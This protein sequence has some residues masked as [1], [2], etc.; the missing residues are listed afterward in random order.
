M[1]DS[2][3][4]GAQDD[5]GR[6]DARAPDEDVGA[7]LVMPSDSGSEPVDPEILKTCAAYDQ[8]DTDNGKRLLAH[9]GA[10]LRVFNEEGA[11]EPQ[12]VAWRGR[13]WDIGA[14]NL[15]AH[16]VAQKV[17]GRI[18]LEAEFIAGTPFEQKAAV[19]GETASKDLAAL[20]KRKDGWSDKDTAK[21]KILKLTAEAGEAA[22]EAVKKRRVARRKFAVSSKNSARLIAMLKCAAPHCAAG[23]DDFNPDPYLFATNGHTLKFQRAADDEC[24][25]PSITRWKARI[26]VFDGHRREDM[27]TRFV[28]HDYVPGATCPLWR[29]FLEEFLPEAD[30][31]DFVQTFSGLGLIGRTVQKLVFHYG[32]GAN[33]KSVFLETLMR[34]LGPLA[35]GLP[36]ESI[37]GQGE[38]SAGGASP[39]LARL[40]AARALRV[41]ELPADKPLHEDLVKKLTGGEKIPV[42]TLFKGYFEFTPVFSCHMSGNG[43]PRIDGTDN[44]I[45]RR[46]AVVHWPVTIPKERQKEFE[47]VL[48]SFAPEYPGILNWLIEGALRFIE[49]GLP[50]PAS[51]AAA[52]KDYRSEM[53]PVADFIADCVEVEEG[54]AEKARTLFDAYVSWSLANARKH[55]F[56]TKFGKVMRQRFTRAEDKG[57]RRY[58][59]V[60][61]HD[62]PDRPDVAMTE[63]HF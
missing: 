52:T 50:E 60:R 14:G 44:G 35:V 56:E 15:F 1:Q 39:D 41:L 25:D 36:A 32:L 13:Y 4:A 62:V 40:Y 24:P 11:K 63:R 29:A 6:V 49:N 54:H 59:D 26:E 42:R 21:A 10:D 38:R 20:E 30:V 3:L 7:A 18:G 57:G 34:V 22:S 48:A 46:L 43:Y 28:P 53:D 55:V 45:W 31:R 51:I 2:S 5:A 9:F 17:G 37:T 47:D 27:L 61:L 58:L 23:P 33:G 19:A 12:Y 8:S 16:A